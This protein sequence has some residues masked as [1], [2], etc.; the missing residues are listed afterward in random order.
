MYQEMN[1]EEEQHRR[2]ASY[3]ERVTDRPWPSLGRNQALKQSARSMESQWR[4]DKQRFRIPRLVIFTAQKLQD[5]KKA[6]H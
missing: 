6:T 5:I 3:G 2:I 4:K 1:R